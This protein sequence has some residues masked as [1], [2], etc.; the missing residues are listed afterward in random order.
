MKAIIYEKYGSPNVLQ[1]KNVEKPIPKVDEVLVKVQ[2]ASLNAGD[3]HA[4]RGT[5]FL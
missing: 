1:L 2:A 3:W 4:L 5:P